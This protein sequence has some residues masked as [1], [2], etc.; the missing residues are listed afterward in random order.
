MARR[1]CL[2]SGIKYLNHDGIRKAQPS[3]PI[4]LAVVHRCAEVIPTLRQRGTGI[5][6][7]DRATMGPDIGGGILF[8]HCG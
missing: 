2:W 5:G 7:G 3:E 4:D 1:W 6:S 8:Q